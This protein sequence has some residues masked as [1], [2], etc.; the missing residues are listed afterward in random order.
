[1][2]PKAN[3][4]TDL[5]KNQADA[6]LRHIKML[7]EMI[8]TSSNKRSTLRA[9]RHDTEDLL[10]NRS[11]NLLDSMCSSTDYESLKEL[12]EKI[13]QERLKLAQTYFEFVEL[14]EPSDTVA[15]KPSRKQEEGRSEI[16]EL[17]LFQLLL[18]TVPTFSGNILEFA[19]FR[20]SYDRAVHNLNI[21]A[22]VKM[23]ALRKLIPGPTG[24]F[25]DLFGTSAED[26]NNAYDNLIDRYTS[27]RRVADAVL[28]LFNDVQPYTGR[29]DLD[30]LDRFRNEVTASYQ[31]LINLKIQN[32]AEFLLF[33]SIKSRIPFQMQDKLHE[34]LGDNTIPDVRRI[35]DFMDTELSKL[36][37]RG[38]QPSS[39]KKTTTPSPVL[40]TKTVIPRHSHVSQPSF[41]SSA[42]VLCSS[43]AH[44]IFHCP[45]FKSMRINTRRDIVRERNLCVNCLTNTHTIENCRSQSHCKVCTAR[46]NTLL[47]KSTTNTINPFFDDHSPQS[48]NINRH[49]TGSP[50]A[51]PRDQFR[52]QSH[53]SN[54][55]LSIADP[56]YQPT[57]NN[58]E[59]DC[60]DNVRCSTPS[61]MR[62]HSNPPNSFSNKQ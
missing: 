50:T 42:C 21:P 20:A 11:L 16:K 19:S 61:D 35:I 33:S 9:I 38:T 1:M 37:A 34:D 8:E 15:A 6:L 60:L 41:Y 4:S 32:L 54:A 14:V 3:L 18:P 12:H 10:Q 49:N 7:L 2:P 62:L 5:L 44:K 29:D 40:R 55:M 25:L 52:H 26:Y 56:D 57:R 47:H 51:R 27:I 48:Y 13:S 28:Q 45:E 23:S 36:R 59:N 31:A 46:H 39:Q 24:S 30:A 43:N 22:H 53:P 17:E 58:M